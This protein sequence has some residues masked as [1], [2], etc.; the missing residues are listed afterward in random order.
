MEEE[1][2]VRKFLYYIKQNG[3]AKIQ[4]YSAGDWAKRHMIGPRNGLCAGLDTV[5]SNQ[6]S[7][8]E[9]RFVQDK[10]S[11][12]GWRLGVGVAVG[13]CLAWLRPETDVLGIGRGV[14][15]LYGRHVPDTFRARSVLVVLVIVVLVL[16]RRVM[17]L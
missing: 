2:N 16:W 14:V 10:K 11:G 17:L 3:S 6:V 9:G 1:K 12:S 5:P 4:P 13:V 7:T 8:T 15:G